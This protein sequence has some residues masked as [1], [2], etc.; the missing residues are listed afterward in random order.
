MLGK[1]A[2]LSRGGSTRLWLSGTRGCRKLGGPTY[3]S[4]DLAVSISSIAILSVEF[5]QWLTNALLLLPTL[6]ALPTCVSV[7]RTMQTVYRRPGYCYSKQVKSLTRHKTIWRAY[8]D[9]LSPEVLP[10]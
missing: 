2:C 4:F 7:W 10:W 5:L 1:N 3:I 8:K 6:S 9:I